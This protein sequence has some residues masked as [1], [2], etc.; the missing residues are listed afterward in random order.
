MPATFGDARRVLQDRTFRS[1][2]YPIYEGSETMLRYG[3]KFELYSVT[4]CFQAIMLAI[5]AIALY[6]RER[7]KKL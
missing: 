3:G 4:L 1:R 2:I 6:I 5:I 7:N